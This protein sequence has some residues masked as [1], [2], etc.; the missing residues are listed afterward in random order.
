MSIVPRSGLRTYGTRLLCLLMCGLAVAGIAPMRAGAGEVEADTRSVLDHIVANY[1][2]KSEQLEDCHMSGRYTSLTEG[3]DTTRSVTMEF[4]QFELGDNVRLDQEYVLRP[5]GGGSESSYTS[6][7]VRTGNRTFIV[8]SRSNYGIIEPKE[9][10]GSL[11]KISLLKTAARSP[12]W[13]DYAGQ[14]AYL[15]GRGWQAD[16]ESIDVQNVESEGRTLIEIKYE[17][18]RGGLTRQ[19]WLVDPA[20]SFGLVQA[21]VLSK[22][23]SGEVLREVTA[24]YELSE[25][26]PGEWRP[27][28]GDITSRSYGEDGTPWS[29]S[30]KI[31][32]QRIEV[33]TGRISHSDF[34]FEAMGLKP[35]GIVD[36]KT[37]R[38]S[39]RYVY[40]QTP[41]NEDDLLSAV[42][43]ASSERSTAPS[44]RPATA[45][46][47]AEEITPTELGH[48]SHSSSQHTCIIWS[49][50]IVLSLL[51]VLVGILA[52]R[53]ITRSEGKQSEAL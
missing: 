25:V 16:K 11:S 22:K 38:P 7:M 49:G 31:E 12:A 35:G 47:S 43:Q 9:K 6:K 51:G 42:E 27:V 44:S 48:H 19:R 36:D 33:N 24:E 29:T 10:F 17:S 15:L 8:D 53:R 4:E 23:R 30:T 37:F 50:V 21:D 5:S 32:V 3:P 18:M 46:A 26:A 41:L 52:A 2:A 20:R 1:H 45:T 14:I 34:K 40:G 28:A 13:S 39:L